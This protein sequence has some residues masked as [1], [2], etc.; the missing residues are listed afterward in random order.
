MS[1]NYSLHFFLKKPR[2]YVSGPK[3][4]YMR[5][6]VAGFTP[7]EASAGRTCEP[8]SWIS[9]ANRAKGN[10][11]SAKTLN[12]YLDAIDLNVEQA[13]TYLKKMGLEISS[14]SIMDKY[15]GKEEKPRYLMEIF[16]D[17][18]Q[19]MEAMIGKGFEANT[20]KGY[21]S[22]VTHLEGY[23]ALDYKKADIDIRK[24][25]HEFILGY[26][27]YLA[28]AKNIGGISVAKYMKHFRKI[29]NLCLA[30]RW[31][32]VNPFAFYK[33][34]AKPKEREFLSKAELDVIEKK[35]FGVKRIEQVL[36]I[37]VFCCYTGLSY[38]DVKKLQRSEI[39][40]GDDGQLWI[41][42]NRKK[43]TNAAR[44][45]LMTFPK[46]LMEKYQDHSDCALKGVVLPVLSNQKMNSYL[47]EIADRCDIAKVLTFHIARHT[48]ATTV[49]L[50]NDVPIESVSKMM[51]HKDIRT[52][53]HYAKVLDMKVSRDMIEL[54]RKLTQSESL[55][56]Q[57]Q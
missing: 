25:D 27:F 8:K 14:E 51:G 48:F 20:L 33:N 34:K 26:E 37:F 4:I 7:K 50:N 28:T 47:K 40:K 35:A 45:P 57:V 12:A 18:N 39:S 9:S 6:T 1:Q 22:S 15:L 13:H 23:L 36:D 56:L 49:T 38:A 31:I 53:Q 41:F 43:N 21:K 46:S 44:I 29:I 5:I 19:K 54:E 16:A 52:T 24:I 10:S 42:T 30:H 32:V 11:E 2:N 3:A 17:H 55:N